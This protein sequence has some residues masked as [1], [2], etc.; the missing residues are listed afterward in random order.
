MT[1]I[2]CVMAPSG[3]YAYFDSNQFTVPVDSIAGMLN[4]LLFFTYPLAFLFN[5]LGMPRLT[6]GVFNWGGILC[7]LLVHGV[8]IALIYN[9]RKLSP[10]SAVTLAVVLGFL[11]LLAIRMIA[12]M[13][14]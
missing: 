3:I 13:P 8:L 6:W 14:A 9:N 12:S 5:E 7:S 2:L 11:D 10:K 1:L 4:L